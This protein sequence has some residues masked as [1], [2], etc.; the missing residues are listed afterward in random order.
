[1]AI[2][3]EREEDVKKLQQ[4]VLNVGEY[5]TLEDIERAWYHY[6]ERTGASWMIFPEPGD[7]L[8]DVV[9]YNNL[10][11]NMDDWDDGEEYW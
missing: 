9:T 4:A 3:K 1:M 10:Y 11:T 5:F 6:S 7:Y 2:N 8:Q